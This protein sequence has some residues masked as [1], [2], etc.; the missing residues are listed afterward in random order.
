[1]LLDFSNLNEEP[2]KSSVAKAFFE[3][4][5]FSGDKID[6]IITYNHKNKGKPLWVEPILW[7][8]GKKGK[9]E[10]FKS[11]AQLILTIGKHKFYTHFPPTIFRGV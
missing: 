4:F 2:L 11:L 3:N 1:M 9:S 7:A 8:E 6:F 5:D 10:L